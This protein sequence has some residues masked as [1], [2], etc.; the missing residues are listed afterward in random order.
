MSKLMPGHVRN[1]GIELYDNQEIKHISLE[2]DTLEALIA[3]KKLLFSF[4]DNQVA[5]EC[6]LFNKKGFCQHLAA[7]EYYLK[8]DSQGQA[9]AL[10]MQTSIE[11][12][13]ETTKKKSFGSEFL[14][15][16]TSQIS[17]IE[18]RFCLSVEG[19]YN[20]VDRNLIWTLRIRRLPDERSYI[21][22]DIRSF[23][24]IVRQ[25]GHYQIGKNYYE[26]LAIYRFDHPSR[27]LIA[28]LWRRLPDS[29]DFDT[30]FF[31]PNGGRNLRLSE[32]QFRKGLSL[33]QS[34]EGFRFEMSGQVM[35]EA[36]FSVLD[37]DVNLFNFTVEVEKD[38]I[39]L[40]IQ[41]QDY[42]TFFSGRYLFY[43]GTFYKLNLR[44]QVLLQALDKLESS[45]PLDKKLQVDLEDKDRMALLLLDLREIGHVQA[46]RSFDIHDFRPFFGFTRVD[47]SCIQVQMALNFHKLWVSDPLELE[48]LPFSPNFQQLRKIFE[49][50][51]SQGFAPQFRS[52]LQLKTSQDFYRFYTETLPLFEEIGEVILSETVSKSFN[53]TPIQVDFA[54]TGNFLDVAFDFEGIDQSEISAAYDALRSEAAYYLS[55]S[56]KMYIFD[57]EIKRVNETLQELR[58]DLLPDGQLKIGN[59]AAMQLAQKFTGSSQINFS[60]NFQQLV[61]DL[62]H[63]EHFALPDLQL[64]TSLRTYQTLGVKW[65][66]MLN[67]YG[68]G[69]IL[70]D[71]MGLGKTLQT[72]AFL[73]ANLQKEQKALIL[74]PSS[75][76]YNWQDEFAKFAPQIDLAV[77][78]GAKT[79]RLAV[80]QADHQVTITSYSAFRQDFE[81]YQERAFDLLILDEAQ[82]MKNDQTK[83]ANYLR[84][85]KVKTCF[86]LSGTPIENNLTELWSIFQIVL[87]DLLPAK[88]AFNKLSAKQVAK[89]IKPFVLRRKKEE[90]LTELPDLIEINQVNELTDDQKAIYL[91]QIQQLRDSLAHATDS[92][93]N[94]K[95]M[96]I[97]SAITRLRQICDTP[98]LFMPDYQG[99]SG[100]LASLRQLLSQV[101]EGE[102]RVLIFSQFRSML[103]IIEQEMDTMGM[104]HYKITGS[105]KADD[106]QAITRAFNAGSRDAVLIS[107]KAGGVGINLTGADMVILVDLWWNPAVE[108]QA[109]ARAYRMGQQKNVEFYRLITRGTIEEKIQALQENK[110]QLITTVLDGQEARSSLSAEDIREILSLPPQ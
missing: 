98:S 76:I 48:S 70:A 22:R 99:D 84:Q 65:L 38:F 45:S 64:K 29:L 9:L 56:G 100:K 63:P 27:S 58:A 31:L 85:F 57:E 93:I 107:L 21:I 110:R 24:K 77:S 73:T 12:V 32:G 60:D 41:T 68:L 20:P 69:G 54:M 52:Q 102:H 14:A 67:H 94:S 50:M 37:A 5:C 42:D 92:E 104:S 71:D 36:N 35:K 18:E 101:Q 6:D 30:S 96:E 86:A 33:M 83:I 25:Q 103:D 87:P 105:T 75:L 8:N 78:Y 23:L 108:D 3:D 80:I 10:E 53:Q 16:L 4:D 79:K 40:T 15:Q 49:L 61:E 46:P 62:R 59:L 51:E 19:E 91:A 13:Q 2:G 74:A 1:Q 7:M 72:I 88:R 97:L 81:A 44:K 11:I 109:V 47:D 55:E 82:V 26:A 34:L 39:E 95:K 17:E 28:F 89:L 106:R 43:Q 90:V 66:S